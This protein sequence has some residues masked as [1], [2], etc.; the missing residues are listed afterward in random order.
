MN[1]RLDP[2]WQH[3][4]TDAKSL[5]VQFR[6]SD[7]MNTIL[8]HLIECDTSGFRSEV[9]S[10]LPSNEYLNMSILMLASTGL[11]N[12]QPYQE[13]AIRW[14]MHIRNA[15]SWAR[16]QKGVHIGV[17]HGWAGYRCRQLSLRGDPCRILQMCLRRE[18]NDKNMLIIDLN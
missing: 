12:N 8:V 13:R 4:W 6:V 9:S 16:H 3:L 15:A 10:W 11:R 18:K 1:L 17:R 7:L 5:V 2:R 14:H